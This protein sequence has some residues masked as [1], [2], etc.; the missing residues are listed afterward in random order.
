MR[1]QPSIVSVKSSPLAEETAG[2]CPPSGI[3]QRETRLPELQFR[4]SYSIVSFCPL[5]EIKS[6]SSIKVIED[7]QPERFAQ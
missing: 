7:S 2:K 6:N 4:Y 3:F 5:G 1:P